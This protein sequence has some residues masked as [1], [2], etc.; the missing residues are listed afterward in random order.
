MERNKH[1]MLRPVAW[2]ATFIMMYGLEQVCYLLC[3][4]GDY[5][6]RWLSVQSTIVIVLL[7]SAFGSVYLG[8]VYAV[9]IYL[10][11]LLSRLSDVIYP[12][13]RGVRYYVLGGYEILMFS[14]YIIGAASGLIIGDINFWFYAR[15]IGVI[16]AAISVMINGR[17]IVTETESESECTAKAT[18]KP[19]ESVQS[20]KQSVVPIQAQQQTATPE[21][22][23]L[24]KWEIDRNTLIQAFHGRSCR[25][26]A[27][28]PAGVEFGEDYYPAKIN[29]MDCIVYLNSERT[30][31]H[32]ATCRYAANCTCTNVYFLPGNVEPCK[33]CRPPRVS[34]KPNWIEK[35]HQY[36][37][38]KKKYNISDPDIPGQ[39]SSET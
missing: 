26:E 30:K 1:W 9:L 19:S 18:T 8:L 36:I 32:T 35:Y 15:C 25:E 12:T 27:K 23:P 33:I 22:R 31:Y 17:I 3:K 6:V 4:L 20:Q 5:L 10:P 13:K 14:I 11:L 28:V 16:L 34:V 39:D 29:V 21:D 38:V 37:M 2:I 7:V 24:T